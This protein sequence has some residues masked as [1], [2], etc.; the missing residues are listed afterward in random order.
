M[1]DVG[2]P[3]DA[4]HSTLASFKRLFSSRKK[5]KDQPSPSWSEGVP[6]QNGHQ[7]QPTSNDGTGEASASSSS[8]FHKAPSKWFGRKTFSRSK[9]AGVNQPRRPPKPVPALHAC[10]MQG[11]LKGLVAHTKSIQALEGWKWLPI[12]PG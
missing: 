4:T 8:S 10:A 1:G 9:A 11:V 3:S 5:E 2:P 7:H 6:E 12:E